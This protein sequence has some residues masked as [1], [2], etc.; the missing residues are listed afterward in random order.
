MLSLG[1]YDQKMQWLEDPLIHIGL[2]VAACWTWRR[3]RAL[4][5][6]TLLYVLALMITPLPVWII[7]SLEQRYSIVAEPKPV[8]AAVVLTGG[9]IHKLTGADQFESLPAIDR[10]L[11]AIRLYK[12]GVVPLIVISGTETSGGE[13]IREIDSIVQFAKEWGVSEKDLV[14]EGLAR[15]TFENARETAI[16]LQEKNITEFYLVTSA[17]HM[18]RAMKVFEKQ[19]TKPLAYPVDRFIIHGGYNRYLSS[20]VLKVAMFRAALHEYIGMAWYWCTGKI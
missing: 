8:Q 5:L 15:T 20:P 19:G 2:L 7:E 11:E 12:K 14:L 13:W 6:V 18:A 17:S 1:C 3:V 10:A 9:T 4:R 16:I